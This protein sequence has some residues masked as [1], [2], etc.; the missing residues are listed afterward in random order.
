MNDAVVGEDFLDLVVGNGAGQVLD[1]FILCVGW[2][3]FGVFLTGPI[4][5]N[6]GY[7]AFFSIPNGP[8]GNY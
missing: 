5:S 7:H 6:S 3:N 4:G 2:G 1:L 8:S